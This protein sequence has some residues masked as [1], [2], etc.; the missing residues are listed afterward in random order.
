MMEEKCE[1]TEEKAISMITE[2]EL[3]HTFRGSGPAIVGCSHERD[4]I[5]EL[6]KKHGAELSGPMA[7]AM[8]HGIVLKDEHG[9]LFIE[10]NSFKDIDDAQPTRPNQ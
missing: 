8:N 10:T 7:S 4:L 2:N 3:V 5:I 1:L 9:W 6:I